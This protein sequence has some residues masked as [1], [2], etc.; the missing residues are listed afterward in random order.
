[1]HQILAEAPGL[2]QVALCGNCEDVHLALGNTAVRLPKE[3][4]L[5]IVKMARRAADHPL[6]SDG[7]EGRYSIAFEDGRPRF[8]VLKDK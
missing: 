4:F 8:S 5:E 2:G 6:L 7:V 1:M 3:V